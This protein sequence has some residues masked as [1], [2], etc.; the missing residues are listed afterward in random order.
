MLETHRTAR[1]HESKRQAAGKSNKK[2]RKGKAMPEKVRPRRILGSKKDRV[3]KRKRIVEEEE[4]AEDE[5]E[6][7]GSEDGENAAP[8]AGVRAHD[9]DARS[10]L[11]DDQREWGVGEVV[12]VWDSAP[13]PKG[14]EKGAEFWNAFKATIVHIELGRQGGDEYELNFARNQR[15]WYSINRLHDSKLAALEAL[16]EDLAAIDVEE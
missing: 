6:E 15:W 7:E 8:D 11:D 9:P 16:D 1:Q 5:E 14:A 10:G 12:W 4:E 13:A 2:G 3:V